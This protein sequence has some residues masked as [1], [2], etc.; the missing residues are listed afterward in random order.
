[1]RID[2]S[3]SERSSLGVEWELE[4]IDLGTGELS[5]G[6][7]A[8]L[9]ELAPA[10]GV[11]HPKA[12]HELLQ[13]CVEVITDVCT[14]V[15]EARAD[16]ATT[17]A[18]VQAAAARR[19]LGVMCSGTHPT[20]DW[21]TQ[22]VSDDDRYRMLIE[23][24]QWLARQLQIFGVHV[25]VGVRGSDKVMPILNALLSYVPH[26]LALSASSPYWIGSDT[27]LASYRSKIFEALPTAGLPYQLTGWDQFE[28]YMELLISTKAI[29]TVRE[30]WWD[31]RPH[32]DF[33][34][35]E[36]RICDGL[37]TLDEVTA[38]AAI[39]QCLVEQMDT[40][41]DRGYTLPEPRAWVV[42][43]NKWRAARYGLEAEIVVDA[44]GTVRPVRV[45][46]L[47]IVEDLTPTARRL[48]CEDELALVPRILEHGASYQRQR[49]VA[50]A[51]GGD[52]KP[53]VDALLDEMRVGLPL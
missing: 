41:L 53:V 47:D 35:V 4:L 11:P 5:S 50:A 7:E 25:H 23:R 40:Q 49:R 28:R 46:L 22:D 33:G 21:A 1:M 44:R 17:V 39:S 43:E 29:E 10:E 8:I 38:V 18:D 6:S 20:T 12:K 27:G 26:L 30:V 48:G 16:L 42:R 36:L 32:P 34:T 31:I 14:T 13:S 51:S 15:A 37:P 2:F 24:N 45:A 52:L 19:G 9:A 3:S